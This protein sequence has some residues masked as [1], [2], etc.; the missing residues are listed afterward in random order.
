MTSL[1]LILLVAALIL[2]GQPLF[3]ILGAVTAYCFYFLGDGML[4]GIVEDIFFAANK[5]LLLAIPLFI[6][7]GNVM[8]QGGIARRLIRVGTALTAPIPAG[9]AVA[10]V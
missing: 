3:V 8:T 10:A 4:E 2:F 1:G 6:L 9:L 5:D 7:A